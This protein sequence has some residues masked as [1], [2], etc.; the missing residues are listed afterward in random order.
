MERRQLSFKLKALIV[1]KPDEIID[2]RRSLRKRGKL[3]T[4]DTFGLE[5]GKEILS[6]GIVVHTDPPLA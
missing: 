6:H 1:V 2:E 5:D 4:V 3:L